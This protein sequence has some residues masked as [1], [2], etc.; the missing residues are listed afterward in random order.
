MSIVA[1]AFVKS[2][3]NSSPS[4]F[5]TSDKSFFW[6][7]HSGFLH[8]FA[9][10]SIIS[11][12]GTKPLWPNLTASNITS[13][14]KPLVSDSTISTASLVPATTKSKVEFSSSAFDGFNMYLPSTK[15]TLEAPTGPINGIPEI[16]SAAE[17]AVIA[18]I[19]GWLSLSY[20]ITVGNNWTSFLNSLGN[21]GLIGLSINLEINCSLSVGLASLLKYPPGILPPA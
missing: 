5:L 10:S 3:V 1:K 12:T 17:E 9:S 2:A 16:A 6:T 20:E 13:S 4:F 14:V 19:S 8:S 7:V 15:P 21:K 18:K 11:I